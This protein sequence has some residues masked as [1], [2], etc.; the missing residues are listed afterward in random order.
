MSAIKEFKSRQSTSRSHVLGRVI[1]FF[2]CFFF[3]FQVKENSFQKIALFPHA[4]VINSRD[5]QNG[6]KELKIEAIEHSFSSC[7]L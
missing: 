3:S 5:V 2:C 1:M 7:N 4:F 6:Y